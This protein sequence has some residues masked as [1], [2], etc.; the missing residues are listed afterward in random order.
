MQRA[1]LTALAPK[2]RAAVALPLRAA[3]G[4]GA[5]LVLGRAGPGGAG[6]NFHF[7]V[8]RAPLG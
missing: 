8:P 1:R 2:Q 6:R 7:H 4:G 3:G 5:R